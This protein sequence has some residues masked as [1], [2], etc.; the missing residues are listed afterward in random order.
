M[1]FELF[2]L[3]CD[4]S[5]VGRKRKGFFFGNVSPKLRGVLVDNFVTYVFVLSFLEVFY[6]RVQSKSLLNMMFVRC[7]GRVYNFNGNTLTSILI[8]R[9]D[10]QGE[11]MQNVT[12]VD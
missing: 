8:P 12:H 1:I 3:S 11:K 6:L 9:R 5:K 10:F 2:M 4:M 7:I